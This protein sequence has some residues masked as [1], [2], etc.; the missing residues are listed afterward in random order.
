MSLALKRLLVAGSATAVAVLGA[1]VPP[2]AAAAEP[3]LVPGSAADRA[4]A[5]VVANLPSSKDVTGEIVTS[6]ALA[7]SGDCTYAGTL[8]TVSSR[9]KD[10]A[11]SFTK[12]QPSRAAYLSIAASA[13][14]LDPKKFGGVNLVSAI[15]KKLPADGRIG[16]Y[17]SAFS[18]ALAV[19]ALKRA[20]ATVPDAVVTKLL[21]LQD[22]ATGAFGYRFGTTL[23]VDPDTTALAMIALKAIGG[24]DDALSR[25][26][27]WAEDSQTDAGYWDNKYSPVDTTG[28]VGSAVIDAGGDAAAAREWLESVQRVDGGL[29]NNLQEGTASNTLAT[30]EALYL[31]NGRSLATASLALSACPSSAPKLP[32]TKTSCSGVWVVVDRGNGQSTVRCAKKYGDSLKALA[33]AGFSVKTFASG[34]STGICQITKFP[35][36]CVTDWTTGYWAHWEAAATANGS[37]GTWTYGGA[38]TE[39]HP[40]KGSAEGWRWEPFAD[41][42]YDNFIPNVAGYTA[43]PTPEIT[44]SAVVGQVLT[45]NT[46]AW[47][48]KPA[49]LTLRWYRN[50]DAIKGATKATYTLTKADYKKRITLKVTASGTGFQWLRVVSAPTVKV[51]R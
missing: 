35:R 44:G 33:S 17:E 5:Y 8:R 45:A 25:A 34:S 37:W 38:P 46:G 50:G 12:A 30:A 1:I 41:G 23:T 51:T 39:T 36:T 27:D 3:D 24:H 4:A 7:S 14:G 6:L 28:L 20:G 26:L 11:A 18:Q 16:G 2:T 29:P 21:S 9:M 47:A 49:S 22:P 42:N 40:A 32:K 31:L 15:T 43:S 19:I 48:P 13:L 10:R